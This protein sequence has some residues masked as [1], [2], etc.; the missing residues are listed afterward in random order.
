MSKFGVG[1]ALLVSF[2]LGCSSSYMPAASPRVA[3]VMD[4]GTWAYVRD[5]KKYPG[6]L[7]GGDL[8][9]AVAGNPEAEKY[10]RQYK[11]GTLTGFVMTFMG[12]AGLIGGLTV[13]DTQAES[14][15]YGQRIPPTG[16]IIAGA[17]LLVELIG[18]GVEVSAVPH[19]TD[20]INAYNDGLTAPAPPPAQ[21]PSSGDSIIPADTDR[22]S[23]RPGTISTD[24]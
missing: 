4:S 7:F 21:P 23:L 13:Y 15:A 20:A 12:L 14:E 3:L 11:A 5:G 19:L 18:A 24:K 6:G 16:L 2:T 9:K 22:L 10:A 1:T 8:D 17:G